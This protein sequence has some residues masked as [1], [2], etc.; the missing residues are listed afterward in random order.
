MDAGFSKT[1][2]NRAGE[3]LREWWNELP[4]SPKTDTD[5]LTGAII[6]LLAF[7][8]AIQPAL[9]K[10]TV[11]VRQF[12]QRET[13]HP[14]VVGQRLKRT[15]Q[16]ISKLARHPEMRLARMQDIGGCRAILGGGTTEVQGVLRR[17]RRNWD[18]KGFKDYTA[19]PA[20]SGYRGIHVIVE[21]DGRLIEIQLRTPHQHDWAEAV[22]RAGLR[23][24][25][26]LK[27]G[28]GPPDLLEY[29]RLAS[30]G[31]AM[32]EAGERVNPSFTVRFA[33]MREKVRPYFDRTGS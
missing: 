19:D 9:K 20:P 2:V 8:E 29:F 26:P 27:E 10:T 16:I 18:V 30:E 15:P 17:I 22:E 24:R 28:A 4:A 7:R 32:E 13:A 23:L 12:V 21:R 1:Q 3:L 5:E 33:A 25:I 11:G 6:T 31:L 14:V